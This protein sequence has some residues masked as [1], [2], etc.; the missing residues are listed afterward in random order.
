MTL[1]EFRKTKW[2][3]GLSDSY[4]LPTDATFENGYNFD[5]FS[6]PG[7][8]QISPLMSKDSGTVVTDQCDFAFLASDGS[9]YWFSNGGKIYKRTSAGTWTNVYTDAGGAILGACEYNGSV[10]WATATVLHCITTANAGSE[11]PW[12]TID[13]GA[14]F[15]ATLTTSTWHPMCVQSI[16]LVIGNANTL[17][18]VDDSG[19]FTASG[20]SDATLETLKLNN[21][22][23][24]LIPYGE[25]V[26]AGTQYVLDTSATPD[27]PQTG[28]LCRWDIASSAFTSIT[29]I[30]DNGV[31]ALGIFENNAIAFC[32]LTGGI[33]LFD[34]TNI[35]K[36]KK[37]PSI[38]T[39]NPTPTAYYY[40]NP[41][42]V[43]T[44]KG[45]LIFGGVPSGFNSAI[46]EL[47][48]V[49]YGYPLALSPTYAVG[50]V[51]TYDY[52][53]I[54][55][56]G[57]SFLV[58]T[59]LASA[60]GVYVMSTTKV[61]TEGGLYF[62]VQGDIEK[63]KNWLEYAVGYTGD[64]STFTGTISGYA[65]KNL[66][67]AVVNLAGSY[68]TENYKYFFHNKISAR[69]MLYCIKMTFLADAVNGTNYSIDSFY[70]KWEE[71]EKL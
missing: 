65:Y 5:V 59:K 9:T 21:N 2:Y 31:Y 64:S 49:K 55:Q 56:I 62:V 44:F 19:V 30:L 1:K 51:L 38:Y 28:Y 13:P 42:S 47:G 61:A 58:S 50:N 27:V 52:S 26:L 36:I 3:G 63:N 8:A 10:F 7:T 15:P 12:A 57:N 39:T 23:S 45:K 11:N 25:D 20:T 48:R 22:I 18:T 54:V 34:G 6:N 16:Y 4:Y 66:Y 70:C 46:Y 69:T 43:T 35:N 60:F 14:V 29:E 32:G 24:C 33:Y 41:G 17:A 71:E 68:Q 53:A 37:V 40:V 67:E